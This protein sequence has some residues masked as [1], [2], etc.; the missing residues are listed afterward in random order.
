MAHR[1][2]ADSAASI[3]L[4]RS[5][6]AIEEKQMLSRKY[7]IVIVVG[8]LH[9]LLVWIVLVC[10]YCLLVFAVS[11]LACGY[12]VDIVRLQVAVIGR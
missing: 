2:H 8:R 12:G 4:S 11:V 3:P 7:A 1:G 10:L 9:R 6:S 5:R